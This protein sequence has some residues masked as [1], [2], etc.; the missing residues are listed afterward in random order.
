MIIVCDEVLIFP[1]VLII[2]MPHYQ[3]PVKVRV[4]P[5]DILTDNLNWFFR[6]YR[7]SSRLTGLLYFL[8]KSLIRS[9][10]SSLICRITVSIRRWRSH[11]TDADWLLSAVTF[12]PVWCIWYERGLICWSKDFFM[13]IVGISSF[14]QITHSSRFLGATIIIA[15]EGMYLWLIAALSVVVIY[16]IWRTMVIIL[17]IVTIRVVTLSIFL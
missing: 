1:L 15:L 9:K 5:I 8:L 14:W 2:R 13:T 6:K 12:L 7:S 11:M 10:A 3:L 4:L 17:L 16:N